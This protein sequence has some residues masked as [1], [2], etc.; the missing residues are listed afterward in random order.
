[1]SS[2]RN[3]CVFSVLLLFR[4]IIFSFGLVG[5]NSTYETSILDEEEAREYLD[6][7]FVLIPEMEETIG[8]RTIETGGLLFYKETIVIEFRLPD[9][10]APTDWLNFLIIA[11]ADKGGPQK[12][13]LYEK[14]SDFQYLCTTEDYRCLIDEVAYDEDKQKYRVYYEYID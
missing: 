7:L 10:L 3:R 13:E 11:Y 12:Y 8:Y 2:Q 6:S 1:M 9:S 14:A 4:L 5:C